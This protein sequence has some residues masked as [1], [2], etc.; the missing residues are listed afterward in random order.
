MPDKTDKTKTA[1]AAPAE[2]RHDQN[3]ERRLHGQIRLAIEAV[4]NVLN[5]AESRH[6]G[7]LTVPT[8]A[9]VA[10]SADYARANLRVL[11][12]AMRNAGWRE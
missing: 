9:T 5:E 10:K 1:T 7:G 6:T 3:N 8:L 11:Q 2:R 4:N 12:E